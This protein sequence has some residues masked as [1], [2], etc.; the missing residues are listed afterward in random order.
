MKSVLRQILASNIRERRY[1]LGLSQ[2]KLAELADIAPSYVAM[3]ELERKFPSV[4]VLERIAWA[5]KM[6]PTELFSKACYPIE[7][8]K[9][10][11][12]S[13]LAS[14]EHVVK[15]HIEEFEA[16]VNKGDFCP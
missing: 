10:L 13:V 7:A 16:K 8:V 4:E 15:S 11:H 3:I 1:V 6:D 5:L 2:M 12:K 9:E 14:F